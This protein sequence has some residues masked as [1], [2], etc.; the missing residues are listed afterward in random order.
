MDADVPL[1]EET[2]HICIWPE[3]GG[4]GWPATCAV[5]SEMEGRQAHRHLVSLPAPHMMNFVIPVW[6]ETRV[7]NIGAWLATGST[8]RWKAALWTVANE[9]HCVLCFRLDGSAAPPA[10]NQWTRDVQVCI[11]TLRWFPPWNL[12]WKLLHRKCRPMRELTRA[13]AVSE[14]C[15]PHLFFAAN[16]DW[17]R[18][19]NHQSLTAGRPVSPGPRWEGQPWAFAELIG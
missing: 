5:T 13:I 3:A 18:L 4:P 19:K 8:Q 7:E 11:S 15:S 1:A 12:W 2:A 6:K 9:P 16:D 17:E 14:K 10:S